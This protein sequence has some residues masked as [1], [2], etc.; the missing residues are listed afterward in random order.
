MSIVPYP[1]SISAAFL[2]TGVN[3]GSNYLF[4]FMDVASDE[5]LR[6]D[7]KRLTGNDFLFDEIVAKA[8]VF[9]ASDVALPNVRDASSINVY[10]IKDYEQDIKILYEKMGINSLSTRRAAIAFLKRVNRYLHLKP[11]IVGVGLNLNEFFSD[12]IEKLEANQP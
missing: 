7:L 8:P 11:N 6:N 4:V 2:E 12:L 9:L 10:P 5:R 1:M 3:T